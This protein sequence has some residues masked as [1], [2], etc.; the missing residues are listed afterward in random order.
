MGPAGASMAL[1][2]RPTDR[3][4]ALG[5]RRWVS[6]G[7]A[8]VQ[9]ILASPPGAQWTRTPQS[10][11]RPASESPILEPRV[12]VH[13]LVGDSFLRPQLV[14][15]VLAEYGNNNQLGLASNTALRQ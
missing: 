8:Q 7:G 11:R 3:G 10:Q 9:H 14:E 2:H 12:A 5:Q 6:A 1:R 4:L 15:L 13:G